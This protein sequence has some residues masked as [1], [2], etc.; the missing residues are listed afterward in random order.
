MEMSRS[1]KYQP[2]AKMLRSTFLILL[3]S[4]WLRM[5]AQ[6]DHCCRGQSLCQL[7]PWITVCS[8]APMV[9][10]SNTALDLIWMRPQ[11]LRWK[12]LCAKLLLTGPSSP[13]SFTGLPLLSRLPHAGVLQ[14]SNLIC[15][16]PRS[17]LDFPKS[18]PPPALEVGIGCCGAMKQPLT[19]AIGV[20]EDFL[21]KKNGTRTQSWKK[22]G[23]Y[24]K[25]M[26]WLRAF[27][28]ETQRKAGN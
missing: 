8:G 25:E 17:W 13:T 1:N 28:P 14:G 15:T 10:V 21:G 16:K 4:I 12:Q 18:I 20:R 7:G 19:Q 24:R 27:P 2:Q 9:P 22:R 23:N 3:F 6:S 11:S 26:G 5:D